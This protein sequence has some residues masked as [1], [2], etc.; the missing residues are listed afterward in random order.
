[1]CR[2]AQLIGNKESC[3]WCI[4]LGYFRSPGSGILSNQQPIR[5]KVIM[6]WIVTKA[7]VYFYSAH[8]KPIAHSTSQLQT[9]RVG[10][11]VEMVVI[12]FTSP[13][14]V[15]LVLTEHSPINTKTQGL[16]LSHQVVFIQPTLNLSLLCTQRI[17]AV[18]HQDICL[19]IQH[20]HRGITKG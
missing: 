10:K 17:R 1:M 3:W 20:R 13:T 14:P 9:Q 11:S 6:F 12:T 5:Q 2:N 7:K 18:S 16:R 19:H 8:T 15:L 4:T